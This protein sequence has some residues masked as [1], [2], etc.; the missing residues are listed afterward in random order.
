MCTAS[1]KKLRL[2]L[3]DDELLDAVEY[4]II[5]YSFHHTQEW[6]WNLAASSGKGSLT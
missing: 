1:L 3:I 4:L 6:P 5:S 2:G